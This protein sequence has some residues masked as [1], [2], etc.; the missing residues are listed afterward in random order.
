MPIRAPWGATRCRNAG[1]RH[2]AAF[3][4]IV[5]RIIRY[6]CRKLFSPLLRAALRGRY[7]AT[8]RRPPRRIS[9]RIEHRRHIRSD[10]AMSLPRENRPTRTTAAT[11]PTMCAACGA[12]ISYRKYPPRNRGRHCCLCN[13]ERRFADMI[14][15]EIPL[16]ISREFV[17]QRHEDS[18][19]LHSERC[20]ITEIESVARSCNLSA[21]GMQ[22][23]SLLAC[24]IKE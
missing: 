11:L 22:Y 10:S 16:R 12:D 15:I 6:V 19:I 14:P 18:R 7:V 17:G 13:C 1:S 3:H 2:P 5:F 9:D 8:T 20:R 4:I 21:A 24:K 23:D